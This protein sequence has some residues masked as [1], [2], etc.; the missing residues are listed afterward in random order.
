M[1]KVSVVEADQLS[2]LALLDKTP[3]K[4][5]LSRCTTADQLAVFREVQAQHTHLKGMLE[6]YFSGGAALP[7]VGISKAEQKFL[8]AELDKILS[9]Y[10]L[11]WF[12]WGAIARALEDQGVYL[13]DI[14]IEGPGQACNVLISLAAQ[15]KL[16]HWTSGYQ[17]RTK[18]GDKQ[19]KAFFNS[20]FKLLQKQEALRKPEAQKLE[21]AY[22]SLGRKF[23]N[24]PD[25]ALEFVLLAGARLVAEEEGRKSRTKQRITA[26]LKD[27][28][29]WIRL[30]RPYAKNMKS[31]EIIKGKLS[32]A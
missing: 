31:Y 26:Y 27:C 15:S 5:Y 9:L 32:S 25:V 29:R 30:V 13:Q 22:K 1:T 17:R 3:P 14:G 19:E 8:N 28:D 10:N 7:I 16:N 6:D 12:E 21:K 23:E 18:E 11:L 20:A 4:T 2:M 24:S